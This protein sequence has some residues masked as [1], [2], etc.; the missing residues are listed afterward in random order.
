MT[1]LDGLSKASSAFLTAML[2]SIERIVKTFLHP[3]LTASF[4]GFP[5]T[6]HTYSYL[7]KIAL[8][9]TRGKDKFVIILNFPVTKDDAI[10]VEINFGHTL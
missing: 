10:V 1:A 8:R 9:N 7:N 3:S 4:L 5:P 6:Y 2:S